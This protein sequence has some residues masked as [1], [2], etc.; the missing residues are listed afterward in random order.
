MAEVVEKEEQNLRRVQKYREEVE[1][2]RGL[3]HRPAS[4][5][6]LGLYP[7]QQRRE[8]RWFL[9]YL[10]TWLL[11]LQSW[12]WSVYMEGNRWFQL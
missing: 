4:K 7:A 12:L 2:E 6:G 10:T 8:R 11:Y 9:P 1:I 5:G 3:F